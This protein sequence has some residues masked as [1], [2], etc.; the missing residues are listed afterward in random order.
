MQFDLNMPVFLYP[1][2]VA[3]QACAAALFSWIKAS[4]S[5]AFLA[6]SAAFSAAFLAFSAAFSSLVSFFFFPPAP[7]TRPSWTPC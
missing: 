5:A 1:A 2:P 7:P 6:F 4:F 3:V